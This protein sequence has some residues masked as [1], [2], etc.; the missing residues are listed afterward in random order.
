MGFADSVLFRCSFLVSVL[1]Y[2]SF[3]ALVSCFQGCFLRSWRLGVWESGANRY[4][5]DNTGN[6]RASLPGNLFP[7]SDRNHERCCTSIPRRRR[8]QD[9]SPHSTFGVCDGSRASYIQSTLWLQVCMVC[10]R[11]DSFSPAGWSM[12]RLEISP[13][14]TSSAW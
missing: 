11:I 7:G 5:A 8:S 9:L 3:N 13:I 14:Q 6:V 10:K 2:C 4:V 1:G 12:N